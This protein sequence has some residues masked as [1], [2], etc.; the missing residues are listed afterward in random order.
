VAEISLKDVK[1]INDLRMVLEPSA[2]ETA[3]NTI[4]ED[5]I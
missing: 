5:Q 2:A 4:L 3:I 1:E